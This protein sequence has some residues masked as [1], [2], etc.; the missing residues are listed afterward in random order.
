MGR[1]RIA[2]TQKLCHRRGDELAAGKRVAVDLHKA[3]M[4]GGESVGI[5]Q[6]IVRGT[7]EE[8]VIV[9]PGRAFLYAFYVHIFLV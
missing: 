1:V 6:W 9:K 8:G 2:Y 4:E 5:T 7:G 3:K